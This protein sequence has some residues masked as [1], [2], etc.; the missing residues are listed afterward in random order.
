[1]KDVYKIQD[2]HHPARPGPRIPLDCPDRT[3]IS[4]LLTDPLPRRHWLPQRWSELLVVAGSTD[5]Q[6][7]AEFGVERVV[8]F[9]SIKH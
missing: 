2:V 8:H 9:S 1:M 6:V 4:R 3:T 7:R 5:V